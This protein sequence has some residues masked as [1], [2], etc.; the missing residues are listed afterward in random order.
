[1]FGNIVSSVTTFFAYK[2]DLIQN[3]SS[4]LQ[5]DF[6]T[7]MKGRYELIY[8][9]IPLLIIVYLFAN[10]FTLAGMGEDFSTNLGLAYRK[11]VNLGLILVAMVSAVVI[12]TVGTIPFLG[13]V[14]PNIV[15]LYK[16][17]NLRDTLPHTAV[18][19]AIF[20]LVCDILGQLII[21][22]YQLSISLTVGVV[23]SVLF[24]YLLLRRKAY[25]S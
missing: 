11:V 16:G 13:L 17:D 1:M 9:S 19:G 8:I 6:S 10:R 23:G 3:M 12:I 22:P 18:L 7:I 24:L 5:G 25:E 2:N 14:V 15:T 21:Y 4:W 20:V